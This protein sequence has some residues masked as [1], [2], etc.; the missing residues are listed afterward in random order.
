M[1]RF[2]LLYAFLVF[3]SFAAVSASMGSELD[4][5]FKAARK[6][7]SLCDYTIFDNPAENGNWE[8]GKFVYEDDE[9][10][11]RE[12]L[13]TEAYLE[14]ET[15][16]A[17]IIK[18]IMKLKH[19]RV[20]SIQFCSLQDVEFPVHELKELEEL[21]IQQNFFPYEDD[22]VDDSSE[23][24]SYA[25]AEECSIPKNWCKSIGASRTIR[26]LKIPAQKQVIQNVLKMP[27][28]Q[29]LT[30]NSFKGGNLLPMLLPLKDSLRELEVQCEMTPQEAADVL[31]NFTSLQALA[32]ECFRMATPCDDFLK[33]IKHL[34]LR[35]LEIS[36]GK[37][38][39]EGEK[40]LR[41][42]ESLQEV[43]LPR[44]YPEERFKS[45]EKIEVPVL[46]CQM[47]KEE[48]KM[49]TTPKLQMRQKFFDEVMPRSSRIN[50]E[51]NYIH[52]ADIRSGLWMLH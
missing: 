20:L 27:K 41:D 32:L 21:E 18:Q 23:G 40:I 10:Q 6:L 8:N 17:K 16:N 19:L 48:G 3:C 30:L 37:I 49:A 33:A 52:W 12:L 29:S 28:L 35:Y 42:W 11:S 4:P 13:I 45:L 36:T 38:R 24:E 46:I 9:G 47:N 43:V 14:C 44:G 31:Q 25:P 26:I 5:E 2:S 15:L 7:E 39:T 22:E 34:P 1:K 51:G 50:K